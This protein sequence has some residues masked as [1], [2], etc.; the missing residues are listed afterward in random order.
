M[1]TSKNII[2]IE[3]LVYK[4]WGRHWIRGVETSLEVVSDFDF[5]SR[6][7]LHAKQGKLK[8]TLL[9]I[10]AND[11]KIIQIIYWFE[12]IG[13]TSHSIP[14]SSSSEAWGEINGQ[15]QPWTIH[16]FGLWPI[17]LVNR[18]SPLLGL[19]PLSPRKMIH[20]TYML[21]EGCRKL[22]R[23]QRVTRA[24]AANVQALTST[25]SFGAPPS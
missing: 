4:L 8:L 23:Q 3:K 5:E 22:N 2:F 7:V 17:F 15:F 21:G 13:E 24:P 20:G 6:F 9:W 16:P 1:L 25:V 19:D 10:F 18:L 12:G 11:L 14:L